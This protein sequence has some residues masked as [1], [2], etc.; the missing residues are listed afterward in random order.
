MTYEEEREVEVGERGPR[1]QK[2]DGV[3]D[4][5]E[6]QKQHAEEVLPRRPDAEPEDGGVD[7]GEEGAVEPAATLGDELRDS[8]RHVGR[9]FC[10]LHVLEP[11]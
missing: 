2:L 8:R 10:A 3:V 1:E 4:E 9:R 11:T 6:L 7:R 5:L